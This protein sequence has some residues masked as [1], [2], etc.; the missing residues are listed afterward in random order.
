[1]CDQSINKY[2]YQQQLL[3]E[4]EEEKEDMEVEKDDDEEEED[5]EKDEEKMEEEDD[6]EKEEEEEKKEEEEEEKE[7]RLKEILGDAE[8]GKTLFIRNIPM[9][10]TEKDLFRF[11]Y[12]Q[13]MI[14][15]V[16]ICKDK[17][18]FLMEFHC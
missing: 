15:Y 10:A 11:F 2:Q 8:E 7:D 3:Q 16:K 9:D 5:E 1:M 13:G 6:E 18:D 12:K 17:F 14:E 4:E